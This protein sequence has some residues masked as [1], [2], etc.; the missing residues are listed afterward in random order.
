MMNLVVQQ[1]TYINYKN[2]I[3]VSELKE[4]NTSGYNLMVQKHI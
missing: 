4:D 1:Y 2:D 3:I